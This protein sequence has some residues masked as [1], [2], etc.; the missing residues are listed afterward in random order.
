MRRSRLA[1]SL[2]AVLGLGGALTARDASLQAPVEDSGAKVSRFGRYSGYS[3]AVYDSG[4]RTSQYLT[5]RGYAAASA[6]VRG[7]GASFGRALGV[8]TA[9]ESQD[10]YE[11]TEWL[12]RQPWSNGRVGMFGGSYLGITQL[13]AAGRKP[14]HLKAIFPVMSAFDLYADVCQGG[15]LKDDFLRCLRRNALVRLLAEGNRQWCSEGGSDHLPGHG[16]ARQ[17]RLEDGFPVAASGRGGHVPLFPGW[18]DGQRRLG[19]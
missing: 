17:E 13:M 8:F 2:L 16:G 18:K 1:I 15:V 14:P 4:I 7:S 19:E 12:A 5:M 6:D 3:P 9:E 11:I 10:A